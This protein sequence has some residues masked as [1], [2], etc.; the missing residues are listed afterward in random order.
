M[1]RYQIILASGSPRRKQLLQDAGF[2]FEVRTKDTEEVFP[3]DLPRHEVAEYLA[4]L[5]AN[6]FEADINDNQ[7]IIAADT[8]VIC[9]NQ[10]L[11]KP[12]SVE[13]AKRMLRLMSGN[14]HK[15]I[16]GVCLM[17]KSKKIIFSDSTEVFFNTLTEAEIENY[18]EKHKPMDKAG[19]YGVQDW[20]GLVGIRSLVG[21]FYNVMGLPVDLVYQKLREF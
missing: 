17:T 7:L 11:G 2:E 18:I 13:D 12:T 21:S 16:T 4:T 6:A 3:Q 10:L 1:N 5:K 20:I 9:N 15:V 14:Q 19:S 8:V